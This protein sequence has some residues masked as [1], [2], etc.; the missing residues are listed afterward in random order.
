M[1]EITEL[2]QRIDQINDRLGQISA[3]NGRPVTCLGK[4][5]CACCYEPVYASTA[6]VRHMLEELSVADYARVMINTEKALEKLKPTGLMEKDMP[7]VMEWLQQRVPCPFLKDGACSIYDRR[8]I[9]CRSHNAVGSPVLCAGPHR[10]MQQYPNSPQASALSGELIIG[11]H[12]QIANEMV[13]DNLL[14]LLSG[15]L[16]GKP[17]ETPAAQKIVFVE[18]EAA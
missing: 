12:S 8:P 15:E 14:A 11:Y 6:E 3:Q 18:K 5:C 9:A 2:H 13:F 17:I 4:G 16:F 7:P 1:K 10:L